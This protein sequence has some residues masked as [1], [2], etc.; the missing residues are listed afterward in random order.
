[1]PVFKPFAGFSPSCAAVRVQIEHCASTGD[2]TTATM[3]RNMSSRKIFFIMFAAAKIRNKKG[4]IA[5]HGVDSLTDD[6]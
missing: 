6:R 4:R 5:V 3:K 2:A 1:M